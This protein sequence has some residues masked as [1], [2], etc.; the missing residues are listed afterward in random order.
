MSY[1]LLRYTASKEEVGPHEKVFR[2]SALGLRVDLA[3]Q[4]AAGA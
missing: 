4:S 2:L 3:E 1:D